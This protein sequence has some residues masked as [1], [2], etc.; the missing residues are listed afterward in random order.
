ML[1]EH[2]V[3]PDLKHVI[4]VVQLYAAAGQYDQA[5][6]LISDVAREHPAI[7]NIAVYNAFLKVWRLPQPFSTILLPVRAALYSLRA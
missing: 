4:P 7:L 1:Q 6:K 3:Q 5:R 2:N